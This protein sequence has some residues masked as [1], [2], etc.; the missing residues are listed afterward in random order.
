MSK[1]YKQ[2]N[3]DSLLLRLPNNLK[4]DFKCCCDIL[5]VPVAE[6]IRVM[7]FDFLKE[8]EMFMNSKGFWGAEG[9]A[10]KIINKKKREEKKILDNIPITKHEIETKPIDSDS[11]ADINQD[12]LKTIDISD[13]PFFNEIVKTRP[14]MSKLEQFKAQ[15]QSKNS[16]KRKR[17]KIRR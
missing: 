14:P 3:D 10:K 11:M 8:N 9:L 2:K 13:D 1:K 15:R 16:Q 5:G 12:V 6:V 17:K 4:N 7:I